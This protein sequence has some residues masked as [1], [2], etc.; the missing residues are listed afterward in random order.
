MFFTSEKNFLF[1]LIMLGRSQISVDTD[2]WLPNYHL[3]KNLS[4]F[5]YSSP[6]KKNFYSRLLCLVG[7]RYQSK[8]D[9]WVQAVISASG[10]DNRI[11]P[12]RGGLP[13]YHLKKKFK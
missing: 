9:I 5:K 10:G 4:N 2:I 11:E 8:T 12:A 6:M 1:P 3:K 7:V 13:N